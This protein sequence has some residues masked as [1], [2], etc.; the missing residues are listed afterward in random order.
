VALDLAQDLPAVRLPEHQRRVEA[1]NASLEGAMVNI[2]STTPAA[3]LFSLRQDF[4]SAFT[5]LLRSA[6]GTAVKIELSDRSFPLFFAGRAL[7][8]QRGVLLLRTGGGAKA[9]GAQ[10]SI[11]GTAVTGFASDPTLAELPARPLPG[12]FSANLRAQHTITIDTAGDLSPAAPIPG[13]PS[14]VD[15]TKLL[16]VLLYVEYVLA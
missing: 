3:R 8:V 16:D 9:V 1:D 5:R 6:A 10:I 13:D 4:S 12:A 14:A 15:A 7:Q 11:D 2:F